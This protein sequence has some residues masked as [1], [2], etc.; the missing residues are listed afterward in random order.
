MEYSQEISPGRRIP[1]E[2]TIG[3]EYTRIGWHIYN[4]TRKLQ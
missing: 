1:R 4:P 3:D 2:E